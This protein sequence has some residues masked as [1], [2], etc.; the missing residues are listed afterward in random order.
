M[1]KITIELDAVDLGVAELLF[2][3]LL[4]Q[5][6]NVEADGHLNAARYMRTAARLCEEIRKG[7]K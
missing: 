7:V 6:H 3:R 5:A 2:E 4:T 1:P